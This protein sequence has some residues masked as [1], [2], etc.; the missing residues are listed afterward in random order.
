M[1]PRL[2]MGRTALAIKY[3]ELREVAESCADKLQRLGE[4][5]WG[6]L[7]GVGG[8]GACEVPGSEDWELGH[9]S[10]SGKFA[11]VLLLGNAQVG[12]VSSWRVELGWRG[13]NGALGEEGTCCPRV[14]GA[15]GDSLCFLF[16]TRTGWG[17]AHKLMPQ[18]VVQVRKLRPQRG[19]GKHRVTQV[20]ESQQRALGLR[21]VCPG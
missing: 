11:G 4:G 18:G 10:S 16:R 2:E 13:Q 6:E 20:R 15:L 9:T 17:G 8:G 1:R 5:R 12:K 14:W 19:E 7:P 3:Q 21:P